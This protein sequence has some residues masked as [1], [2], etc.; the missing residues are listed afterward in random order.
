MGKIPMKEQWKSH[1][2]WYA[3]RKG[4]SR[5]TI[6]SVPSIRLKEK[7]PHCGRKEIYKNEFCKTCIYCSD[8][9][10][11]EFITKGEIYVG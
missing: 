10:Y 9:Y 8:G 6:E 2:E 4:K 5:I 1:Q 11:K 3:E 7:C